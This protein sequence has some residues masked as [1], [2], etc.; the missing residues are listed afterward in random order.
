MKTN[1]VKLSFCVSL[2][3]ERCVLKSFRSHEMGCLKFF[4]SVII[5]G[6]V[7]ETLYRVQIHFTTNRMGSSC[8]SIKSEKK[9]T[10]TVDAITCLL[11]FL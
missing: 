11:G 10:Y 8:V 5:C 6:L 9:R 2:R 3:Y 7:L 4:E 1:C